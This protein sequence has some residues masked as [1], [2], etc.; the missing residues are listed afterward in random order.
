M[1]N[2]R[3]R[4]VEVVRT[5][6]P[7]ASASYSA[8]S[9]GEVVTALTQLGFDAEATV[10]NDQMDLRALLDRGPDLVW[11][12]FAGN[13]IVPSF[14]GLL[15]DRG[16]RFVGSGRNAMWLS[17][18]K[19]EA[20]SVVRQAGLPTAAWFRACPGDVQREADLPVDLPLFVKP[21][22]GGGGGGIDSGSLVRRWQDFEARV[23]TTS[24]AGAPAAL[25][26]AYL[27]GREFT[28]SVLPNE[29][30]TRLE[31]FAVEL[32]A[33]ADGGSARVL[34]HAAKLADREVVRRVPDEETDST[35]CKL[36]MECFRVLGARD[37]GR[38]DFRMDG[39][40]RL[41]FLEA[42]L[43]P[44][45]TWDSYFARACRLVG[46]LGYAEVI[47]RIARGAWARGVDA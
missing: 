40:G 14:T 47:G 34:G 25:V 21:H 11:N 5:S 12:G 17:H 26:E 39:E 42:N 46:G 20:K 44:Q 45:P 18:R 35:V 22:N 24:G 32:I 41:Q 31:A 16:Q 10:V 2:R 43:M 3:G 27:P 38:V 9:A 6:I 8:E 28:V 1:S 29:S 19:D 36:C 30:S 13:P 23:A 4:S 37:Y 15:T 7:G 33:E